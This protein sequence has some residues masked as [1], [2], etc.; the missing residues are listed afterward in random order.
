[1]AT[2][3]ERQEVTG[4]GS[5]LEEA[6]SNAADKLNASV[7]GV[8][9][10]VDKSWFRNEHGSMVPKDTVRVTAW[11]RDEGELKVCKEAASWLGELL[12]RMDIEGEVT[13]DI[14]GDSLVVL[15][16]DV[17]RPAV[18][19]GRN[20]RTI[21]GVKHL[22]ELSIGQN[23]PDYRFSIDIPDSR[24]SREDTRDRDRPRDRDR[25]DS[26]SRGGRTDEESAQRLQSMARKI[27]ERV[28]ETGDAEQV[29][30]ELNSYDRRIVHKTV[31][32][33]DGVSTR[34]MGEGSTKTIEIHRENG[35]P[36]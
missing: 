6:V 18:L 15:K 4:E 16:A 19:V 32:E 26:R 28:L 12:Q 23:Y 29:R 21:K 35:E 33:I 25:D 11:V 31:S 13:G 27:A 3:Q 14:E 5:D 34:S 9:W 1:M 30:R 17:A 24:P 36:A 2:Q 20:A 8:R 10:A 22:L 7:S